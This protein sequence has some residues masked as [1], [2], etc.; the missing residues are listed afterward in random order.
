MSICKVNPMFDIS[1]LIF[2]IA[3]G[4]FV[5]VGI[6]PLA[7]G[8]SVV[9]HLSRL[10]RDNTILPANEQLDFTTLVF[11]FFC[12]FTYKILKSYVAIKMELKYG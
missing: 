1:N 6:N 3:A 9:S 8:R 2:Y 5:R 11:L 10:F 12:S 7:N 4:C